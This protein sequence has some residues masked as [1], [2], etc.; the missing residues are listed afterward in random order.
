MESLM[1]QKGF[2]FDVTE[3]GFVYTTTK[4]TEVRQH[5]VALHFK[6]KK[7]LDN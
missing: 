7:T 1:N 5:Q 3:L 2:Y 4:K 6:E